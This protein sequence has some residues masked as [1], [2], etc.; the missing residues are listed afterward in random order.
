MAAE[1]GAVLGMLLALV[2]QRLGSQTDSLD[3]TLGGLISESLTV[4]EDLRKAPTTANVNGALRNRGAFHMQDGILQWMRDFV[5][6]Y[7]GMTRE[8]DWVGLMSRR[9]SQTLASDAIRECKTRI[10]QS[11]IH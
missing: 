4:Y 2:A 9:Q 11:S 5:L 1:D 10:G 7:S 8:T 6:R 3:G